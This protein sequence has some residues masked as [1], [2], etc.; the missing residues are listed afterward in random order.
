V[1]PATR[2]NDLDDLFT[3]VAVRTPMKPGGIIVKGRTAQVDGTP[4]ITLIDPGAGS[5]RLVAATGEP[6]PLRLHSVS[7]NGDFSFSDFEA[8]FDPIVAP[9]ATEIAHPAVVGR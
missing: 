9:A 7:G 6:Y 1:D 4:A 8:T 3:L 2:Q 5:H